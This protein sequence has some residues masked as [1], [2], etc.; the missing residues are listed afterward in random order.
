MEE[1]APSCRMEL[2]SKLTQVNTGS[3]Y[4]RGWLKTDR[5]QSP[6][7]LVDVHPLVSNPLDPRK[8]HMQ[9]EAAHKLRVWQAHQALALG[10]SAR[11]V[12]A[13]SCGPQ[14]SPLLHSHTLRQITRFIDIS[15]PRHRRVIGQQ[16]QRHHMQERAECA[17]MLG[18]ADDV[19]AFAVA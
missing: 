13:A 11:T 3:G 6:L 8:H 7:S 12:K 1:M 16:L 15:P 19:D 17:V 18:H 14:P 2:G 5:R 9:Q 4:C 10:W